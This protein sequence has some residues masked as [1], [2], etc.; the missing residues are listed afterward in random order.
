MKYPWNHLETAMTWH[1]H[2]RPIRLLCFLKHPWHILELPLKLLW[3]TLEYLKTP[4]THVLNIMEH[5]FFL[6]YCILVQCNFIFQYQPSGTEGTWTCSLPAMP[7]QL[8]NGRWD[9]ERGLV[10]CFWVLRS[11]S[12]SSTPPMRKQGGRKKWGQQWPL[13][14]LPVDCLNGDRV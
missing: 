5:N 8:Q 3:Y 6:L 7:H 11:N 4:L 13:F 10:L 12:D 1:F 9:L 2:E 14:S